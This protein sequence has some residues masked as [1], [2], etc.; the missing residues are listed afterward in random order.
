MIGHALHRRA[1]PFDI[2]LDAT[3]SHRTRRDDLELLVRETLRLGDEIANTL[4]AN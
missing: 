1:Q 3:C 2:Q 4:A